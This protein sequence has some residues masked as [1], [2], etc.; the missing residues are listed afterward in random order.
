MLTATRVS[1]ALLLAASAT[2]HADPETYTVDPHHTFPVFEVSHYGYSMQRGRFNSVSGSIVLDRQAG[3][4][5]IDIAIDAASLD[6]GLSDWDE[7]LRS[8]DFFD[9]ARYPRILFKAEK[10]KFDGEQLVSA[11]GTLTMHGVSKPV[12]LT[13][14]HFH[15]GKSRFTGNTMCGADA[16]AKIRRSDFGMNKLLPGVGDDIRISIAIEAAVGAAPQQ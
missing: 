5:S 3:R 7:K 4:G 2:A 8:E 9:V 13:V 10:L 16:S 6:M 11:D 12:A 1:M 15:C 14:D